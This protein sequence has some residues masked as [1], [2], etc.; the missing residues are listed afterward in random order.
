MGIRQVPFK[1]HL[2]DYFYAL[3]LYD[4]N[5]EEVFDLDSAIEAAEARYGKTGWEVY[6]GNEGTNR[7]SDEV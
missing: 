6:N 7:F 4:E 5:G 2:Q 1:I 3:E